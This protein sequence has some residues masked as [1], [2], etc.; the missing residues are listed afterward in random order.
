MPGHAYN[1]QK[2][3]GIIYKSLL[4]NN[5]V[6]SGVLLILLNWLTNWYY[7]NVNLLEHSG[8]VGNAGKTSLSLASAGGHLDTVRYLVEV[9]H[10]DPRRELM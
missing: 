1:A 7:G 6:Y 9:H 5:I 10:C 4:L 2:Y 3:A 8:I